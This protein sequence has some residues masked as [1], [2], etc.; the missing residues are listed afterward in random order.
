VAQV[1]TDEGP[2]HVEIRS[3]AKGQTPRNDLQLLI[4]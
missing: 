4:S 1:P 3:D 2:T